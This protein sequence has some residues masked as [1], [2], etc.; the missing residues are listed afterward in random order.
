MTTIEDLCWDGITIQGNVRV[1]MFDFDKGEENVVWEG[2]GEYIGSPWMCD[3]EHDDFP[4]L[5]YSITF[6]YPDPNEK[7]VLH[8]EVA[9]GEDL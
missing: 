2:D 7:D 8:I 6:I 1:S 4:W 9:C 3:R 5:E